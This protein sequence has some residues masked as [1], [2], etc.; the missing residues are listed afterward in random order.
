MKKYTVLRRYEDG[1]VIECGNE[2]TEQ[3]EAEIIRQ[4]TAR[5]IFEE[6]EQID[7]DTVSF[8]EFY[9]KIMKLKKKYTGGET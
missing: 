9:S 8:Q 3:R 6:I 1:T 2:K 4:N 5:E 7:E